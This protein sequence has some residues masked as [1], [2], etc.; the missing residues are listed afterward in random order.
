MYLAIVFG[1]D[2]EFKAGIFG[3]TAATIADSNSERFHLYSSGSASKGLMSF[4]VIIELRFRLPILCLQASSGS[5]PRC[6]RAANAMIGND[7]WHP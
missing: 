2:F 6:S 5:T 7:K 3:R 4:N 1:G